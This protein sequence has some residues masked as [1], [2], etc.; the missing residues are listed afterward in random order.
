[1][2]LVAVFSVCHFRGSVARLYGGR[3][4][5]LPRPTWRRS[6]YV[7]YFFYG[8]LLLELQPFP[9][10]LAVAWM[11]WFATGIQPALSGSIL[12]ETPCVRRG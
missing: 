5:R 3:A 11:P 1:M 4:V 12:P 7:F 10:V 2:R 9:C 6:I 8:E